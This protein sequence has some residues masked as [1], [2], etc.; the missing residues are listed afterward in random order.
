MKLKSPAAAARAR[1]SPRPSSWR[2]WGSPPATPAC[3]PPGHRQTAPEILF[4]RRTFQDNAM[5]FRGDNTSGI[6]GWPLTTN[7]CIE[8]VWEW[9]LMFPMMMWLISPVNNVQDITL[10]VTWTP[11]PSS[12]PS[13][14]MWPASISISSSTL[15]GMAVLDWCKY[16]KYKK[17]L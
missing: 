17:S 1:S 3:W 10:K 7:K 14:L 15:Y 8:R 16:L 6:L 13:R 4:S 5:H 9:K 11:P 2:P 12:R